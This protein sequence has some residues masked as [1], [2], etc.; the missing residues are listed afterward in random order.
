[1][2]D[3]YVLLRLI[4]NFLIKIETKRISFSQALKEE[5]GIYFIILNIEGRVDFVGFF[6]CLFHAFCQQFCDLSLLLPSLYTLFFF[7]SFRSSLNV[8][9]LIR[10]NDETLLKVGH[11]MTLP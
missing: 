2:I 10:K 4:K 7:F 3:P 9:M 8:G 6:H 1:M 11:Q 5:D